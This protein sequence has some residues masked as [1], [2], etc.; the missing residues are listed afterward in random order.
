MW[1]LKNFLVGTRT[2]CTDGAGNN[3][4][5]KEI[6]K[7]KCQKYLERA[8]ALKKLVAGDGGVCAS[9]R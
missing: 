7:K 4:R 6:I 8:E 5:A 3:F 1:F 9:K 2:S